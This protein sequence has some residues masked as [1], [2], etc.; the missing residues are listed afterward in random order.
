MIC[1]WAILLFVGDDG[2]I[3]IKY[4]LRRPQGHESGNKDK[5][6][7]RNCTEFCCTFVSVWFYYVVRPRR[8]FR[9][10]HRTYKICKA[11]PPLCLPM[12]EPREYSI[13]QK[14]LV[15]STTCYVVVYEYSGLI[16][17][18]RGWVKRGFEFSAD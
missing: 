18:F 9:V 8:E 5:I 2:I 17:V 7:G 4:D 6:S 12:R 11:K 1:I 13:A 16:Y 14:V 10:D 3:I 15:E